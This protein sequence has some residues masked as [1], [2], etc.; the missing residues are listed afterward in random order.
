MPHPLLTT[1]YHG[2]LRVKYFLTLSWS[3]LGLILKSNHRR[4][5]S[6]FER[7]TKKPLILLLFWKI[8]WREVLARSVIRSDVAGFVKHFVSSK[9]L[10]LVENLAW[11]HWNKAEGSWFWENLGYSLAADQRPGRIPDYFSNSLG[12]SKMAYQRWLLGSAPTNRLN[13]ASFMVTK[14]FPSM[15]LQQLNVE[16][17]LVQLADP[18]A[19]TI[20]KIAHLS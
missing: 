17:C 19:K 3:K 4:T 6:I 7:A 20:S 1:N 8:Y 16:A 15:V 5:Y 10:L 13:S 11:C 9:E 18:K 12:A 14:A 2:I